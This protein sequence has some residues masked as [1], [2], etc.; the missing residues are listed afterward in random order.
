MILEV[1]MS[2]GVGYAL[3][4]LEFIFSSLCVGLGGHLY[5]SGMLRL[6]INTYLLVVSSIT[7][8]ASIVTVLIYRQP[9]LAGI[10]QKVLIA[11][12]GAATALLMLISTSLGDCTFSA[13]PGSLSFTLAPCS[14][15]NSVTAF[16]LLNTLV[17][18]VLCIHLSLKRHSE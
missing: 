12:W 10:L 11:L 17:M 18:I 9:L 4:G 2:Q 5:G 14:Q 6:N 7:I 16:A 1:L 3:I 13:E 15:M 8:V